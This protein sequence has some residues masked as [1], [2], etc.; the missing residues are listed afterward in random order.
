[1]KYLKNYYGRQFLGYQLP[2]DIKQEATSIPATY[3]KE[4]KYYCRR[5]QSRLHKAWRLPDNS[6]YCRNCLVFGRI[7]TNDQICYF[8]QND[9]SIRNYLEWQGQLTP[10]QKEISDNLVTAVGKKEDVW[11]HAVTGS[12][13]TEMIYQVVATALSQ[14]QGVALV[15]P[16]IDV[17]QELYQRFS[18][19]FS[20][21]ITLLHMDSAPYKRAP[22]LISTI[23]QLFRFY[24]AFDLIIIDEVDAFPYVDNPIL[25]QAVTNALKPNGSRIFLTATATNNLEKQVRKKRLKKLQ[26]SRRFHAHPLVVPKLVW[27][28]GLEKMLTKNRLPQKFLADIRKQRQSHYPLLIFY[29]TIQ[30]GELVSKLLKHYFPKENIGFVSSQTADRLKQVQAFRDGDIGILVATTIL[31]RGVTFPEVDVFILKANHRLYTSSSLIQIS[32][33]VGRSKERPTG[34]LVFYHDGVTK[35]MKKS[36][37]EIKKM[38]KRG[39][40]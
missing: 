17:C 37:V 8:P 1:M 12:G 30:E 4:G 38:N 3:Q 23:H 40:F 39:D 20:C 15:S 22:L 16:R 5:C 34:E 2:A 9:F 29:P 33:R 24:Q 18:R 28:S 14:G 27:L 10:Q 21:P 25:Y 31:E 32:G 26:L 7:T 11:V 6:Y 35:Q 19:D 36:I 13:K